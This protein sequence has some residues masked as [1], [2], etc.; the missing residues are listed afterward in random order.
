[1][2]T[3]ASRHGPH[4]VG[5]RLKRRE[6]TATAEVGADPLQRLPLHHRTHIVQHQPAHRRR[7]RQV[8]L[9][10]HHHA[11]QP[12]H[13]GTDPVQ[14]L[15]RSLGLQLGK[16]C[17]HVARIDRDLVAHRIGQP[18]AAATPHHIRAHDP[19]M[20]GQGPR[21]HI[22]IAP[23]PRQT[24]YAHHNV[25][26]GRVAELPVGHPVRRRALGRGGAIADRCG[27]ARTGHVVE[28]RIGHVTRS[29]RKAVQTIVRDTR[30]TF[31][32]RVI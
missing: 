27:Q 31:G 10:G 28:N 22:E 20:R 14:R 32:I 15:Q 16:Q 24:M 11:D 25:G 1:M 3:E 21:Q 4:R 8:R 9:A 13:A 30:S 12:P 26:V 17:E 5:R 18:I 19:H 2:R 23:L 7:K 6:L 29:K